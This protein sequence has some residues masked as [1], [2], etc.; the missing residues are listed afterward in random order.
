[1]GSEKWQRICSRYW[2][3]CVQW[4]RWN[5]PRNQ[6]FAEEIIVV[7]DDVKV[8]KYSFSMLDELELAYAVT[9]HKS[10]GSEYPAVVIPLMTGPRVLFN[11]NLLYTAVTRA[12]QCVTMVGNPSTVDFMIQNVN[13]QLRYS[14]LSYQL[15]EMKKMEEDCETIGN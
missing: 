4:R 3:W 2:R 1:M 15:K 14:G 9:I 10:Q 13:E 5:Y 7:F 11:R 6:F 12:K 8:V